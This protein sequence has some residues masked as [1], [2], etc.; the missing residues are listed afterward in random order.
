MGSRA[1][2]DVD[3]QPVGRRVQL[4]VGAT[5]LEAAQVAGVD[6]VAVCGGLGTC[7]TCRVRLVTGLLSTEVAEEQDLFTAAESRD[8]WRL[9]C[10][11][12]LRSDVRIEIPP[13]SLSAPQRLQTE[14]E[15]V[16]VPLDPAVVAVDLAL[17]PPTLDDLRADTTRLQDALVLAGLTG[18]TIS[19]RVAGA[20]SH[21]LRAQQWRGR[22]AVYRDADGRSALVSVQPTGRALLGLAVDAG[23]TKLAAYLIDLGS[24]ETLARAG[25]M[26]PQIAFGEDVVSRITYA[27]TS[28]GAT[29][30][31]HLRLVNELN[32]LVDELC[33]HAN[34]EREQIVDAVVVGN[35]AMHHLVAGLPVRQLGEAPYV[36]A[37]SDAVEARAADIGLQLAEGAT[38]YLPPNI[39]GYV[40]AD[41]VAMLLASGLAESTQTVLALD[42]GTNTEISLAHRGTIWSCSTAS[43]PAFEGARIHDGMRAAQGAIEHVRF[44]EGAFRVQTIGGAAAVGICGSG[45]LDAIAQSL[46]AGIIDE[47]GSLAKSHPLVSR[48]T[49]GPACLLVPAAQAGHGRDVVF[50]RSDVNEIQLAKGAIRAGTELLLREAGIEAG[51]LDNIVVAGAFGTYLDLESA[52]RV[53]MLLDV[54]RERYRQIGNAAGRGA[55]QLLLSRERRALANRLAKRVHYVELTTHRSFTDMFVQ[56]LEFGPANAA[57]MGSRSSG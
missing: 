29:Q 3:L 1:P 12:Q 50:T 30:V 41:H 45:I 4:T 28:D 57:E 23:T 26:N 8:G 55:E 31:L 51:S 21:R 25:A 32:R 5:I 20:C 24:G 36:A 16:D 11:A 22:A 10:R 42:I 34:A 43:G 33:M 38:L 49:H 9:A 56:S 39:A 18:T 44:Q 19:L 47:R 27:N 40:G 37:V 15:A 7:G 2:V 17:E 48:T 13:E 52:I 6:L 46:D 14:G 53:G 35:T 54:G